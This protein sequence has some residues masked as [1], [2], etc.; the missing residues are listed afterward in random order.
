MPWARMTTRDRPRPRRRGSCAG[1]GGALAASVTSA[2]TGVLISAVP[3]KPDRDKIARTAIA[4]VKFEAGNVYFPEEAPRPTDLKTELFAVPGSRHDDQCDSISQ[5]LNDE[6]SQ[7]LA[8][9]LKA[10]SPVIAPR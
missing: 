2:A 10:Y 8:I 4:S 6:R 9:Y 5:A 3:V 1:L 7:D